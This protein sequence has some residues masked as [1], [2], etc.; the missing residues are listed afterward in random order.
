MISS[1]LIPFGVLAAA[2]AAR[3]LFLRRLTAAQRHLLL[4]SAFAVVALVPVVAPVLPAASPAVGRIRQ[5]VVLWVTADGPDG[6]AKAKAAGEEPSQ[7]LLPEARTAIVWIWSAGAG[8]LLLRIVAGLTQRHRLETS[9]AP[10]AEQRIWELAAG[11]A[12]AQRVRVRESARI[13][14]PETRGA[15]RPLILLPVAARE[16]DSERLEFVLTHELIHILRHDWLFGLMAEVVTALHWYNPLAWRALHTLRQERELACD[17][18]VLSR[19]IDGVDYAGHLVEIAA[20]PGCRTE[21]GA[22]AMAHVSNLETRVRL[23][24]RPDIKRGGV[25]MT[26]KVMAAGVAA[27]MVILLSGMQAPA[28]GNAALSGTVQDPSGAYVPGAVVVVK[29]AVDRNKREIARTDDAGNYRFSALPPGKYEIEVSKPGFK[30]YLH[31]AVD[32]AAGSAQ[33]LAVTLDVGRIAE[34]MT[35]TGTRTGAAVAAST[36][37]TPGGPKRIRVGGNMQAAKLVKQ[38]RPSYPEHMKT[39][40]IEGTVLLEAVI[41]REGK[42]INVQPANSLVHPDLV[43]SAIEA[44]KQWEYEPT[45]LNGVP[46]EIQTSVQINYTLAK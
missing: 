39:Q 33:Q 8:L 25:T 24:L 7:F 10:W 40:G 26:G 44:V 4:V 17:D 41:S 35:V 5:T 6:A 30:L 9:S 42:V 13:G 3:H 38:I 11:S 22:V 16:W 46:V 37:P 32:L 45:H 21:A 12:V 23:I 15:I 20:G 14:V 19:G 18:E 31:T 1:I 2:L 27:V 36:P 29:N 28:Q 43:A 34:T